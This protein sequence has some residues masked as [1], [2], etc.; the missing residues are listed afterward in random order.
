M[1]LCTIVGCLKNNF[2][3]VRSFRVGMVRFGM[4]IKLNWVEWFVFRTEVNCYSGSIL[5]FKTEPWLIFVKKSK[6]IILNRIIF[7]NQ[8]VIISSNE[9]KKNK[10]NWILE[11][12]KMNQIVSNQT[13]K[14]ELNRSK[15]FQ[16]SSKTISNGSN[17]L[18]DFV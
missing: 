13:K 4:K 6:L 3:N 9:R 8:I 18:F 10:R 15:L 11:L 12:L 17:F 2:E 7:F 1:C 14:H 16:F 5:W